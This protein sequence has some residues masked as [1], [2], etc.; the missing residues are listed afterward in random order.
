MSYLPCSVCK[1][2]AKGK[3]LSA[4][5]ARFLAD[6][7]RLAIKQRLCAACFFNFISPLT[8]ASTV[9][10][11][12]CPACGTPPGASADAVFGTLYA[13]GREPFEVVL[14]LDA[15]CAAKTWL[16]LEQGSQLLPDRS[17]EL[18]GPSPSPLPSRDDD[19]S[20]LSF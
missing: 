6:G 18:R 1:Q 11:D 2:R 7:K 8:S 19:W 13:P 15:G 16:I 9:S 4:Y 10:P 17:G 14:L 12:Q 3:M 20:Q 5:W